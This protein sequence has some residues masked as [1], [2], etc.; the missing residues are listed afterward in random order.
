MESDELVA[1]EQ[2]GPVKNLHAKFEDTGSSRKPLGEICQTRANLKEEGRAAG[3]KSTLQ[4]WESKTY[5]PYLTPQKQKLKPSENLTKSEPRMRKIQED[6]T[7]RR[8]SLPGVGAVKNA[9]KMYLANTGQPTGSRTTKVASPYPKGKPRGGSGPAKSRLVDVVP[10]MGSIEEDDENHLGAASQKEANINDAD[11]RVEPATPVHLEGK[12][13]Q[14]G[15]SQKLNED[16]EVVIRQNWGTSVTS[17]PSKTPRKEGG[18]IFDEFAVGLKALRTTTKAR[19]ASQK[20]VDN[21]LAANEIEG[22]AEEPVVNSFEVGLK[23]LRTPRR[24]AAPPE[25]K[26]RSATNTEMQLDRNFAVG[27][28]ALKTPQKP[29]P[30]K[31]GATEDDVEATC[32]KRIRNASRGQSEETVSADPKTLEKGGV[33]GSFGVNLRSQGDAIKNAKDRID[34]KEEEAPVFPTLKPVTR[35]TSGNQEERGNK[36]RLEGAKTKLKH[37]NTMSFERM[38]EEKKQTLEDEKK[39][40]VNWVDVKSKLRHV[41]KEELQAKE[42]EKEVHHVEPFDV[43]EEK[44]DWKKAKMNLRQTSRR[45]EK[46]SE[47]E[48]EITVE[49]TEKETKIFASDLEEPVKAEDEERV[50][51]SDT[52]K[53]ATRKTECADFAVK[54]TG[55][56]ISALSKC[57]P[58]DESMLVDLDDTVTDAELERLVQCNMSKA[59]KNGTPEKPP[60]TAAVSLEQRRE[61]EDEPKQT[62]TEAGETVEE[63]EKK[64]DLAQSDDEHADVTES[65]DETT[66]EACDRKRYRSESSDASQSDRKKLNQSVSSLAEKSPLRKKQ[67]LTA[68]KE[69]ENFRSLGLSPGNLF[70]DPMTPDSNCATSSPRGDQTR[71]R[72]ELPSLEDGSPLGISL[73]ESSLNHSSRSRKRSQEHADEDTMEVGESRSLHKEEDELTSDAEMRSEASAENIPAKKSK[74]E[75]GQRE[76]DPVKF[77]KPLLSEG[78]TRRTKWSTEEDFSDS[79]VDIMRRWKE[80]RHF[81]NLKGSPRT[82]EE[83]MEE[84]DTVEQSGSAL[85]LPQLEDSTQ[86]KVRHF[87]STIPDTPESSTNSFPDVSVSE[88]SETTSRAHSRLSNA[89]KC[90]SV[91][92]HCSVKSREE[93]EADLDKGMQELEKRLHMMDQDSSDEDTSSPICRAIRKG[94]RQFASKATR[95]E[96][97][98][99]DGTANSEQ[100]LEMEDP[101]DKSERGK[102]KSSSSGSD[103]LDFIKEKRTRLQQ[104]QDESIHL[105]SETDEDECEEKSWRSRARHPLTRNRRRSRSVGRP[106]VQLGADSPKKSFPYRA[107]ERLGLCTPA[108]L[109]MKREI[110]VARQVLQV[111]TGPGRFQ[112]KA[113]NVVRIN[114]DDTRYSRLFHSFDAKGCDLFKCID[115]QLCLLHH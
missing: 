114:D 55:K 103:V 25:E 92:S 42:V 19:L 109:G 70:I 111:H 47:T 28:R 32:T 78:R 20:C 13:V 102:M 46:K 77:K 17:I 16:S 3:I 88:V 74:V 61:S 110:G 89:S 49:E 106:V 112:P 15:T 44:I 65:N 34:G 22:R 96:R 105:D 6:E 80:R 60:T 64:D 63:I 98:I 85:G 11:R 48:I 108:S 5:T 24:A 41:S 35:N 87:L 14:D 40:M 82:V 75:E 10:S 86:S 81:L 91:L 97:I 76:T 101:S 12:K 52:A 100:S 58:A 7:S 57:N 67:R 39:E 84:E 66:S 36:C 37:V 53:D 8:T 93:M 107:V 2:V 4:Q 71:P 43:R 18:F 31:F 95:A 69:S 56:N 45:D 9:L 26:A 115:S 30:N 54:G 59:F 50:E 90:S 33:A 23:A 68:L 21:E 94:P 104:I 73:S 27:L 38:A 83:R 29:E 72:A 1:E 51:V 62:I 79:T 113:A 99:S